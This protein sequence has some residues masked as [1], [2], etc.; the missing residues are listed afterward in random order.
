VRAAV[1]SLIGPAVAVLAMI[2]A[3]NAALRR[4]KPRWAFS[5]G[6]LMTVYLVIAT[7]MGISGSLWNWGGALAASIAYPIWEAGPGNRWAEIMW[8]NLPPGLMVTSRDAL[9]GF[10]LG[11]STPYN[12]EVLRAWATPVFWWTAWVTATLWVMMC[13]SVI[14]R[15]RWS[16]EEQ[17]PF[18]M[19]MVPLHVTDPE[20]RLF[21]SPLWWIGVCVAVGVSVPS[22][23]AIFVPAFPTIS[24]SVDITNFLNNNKPWDAIRTTSLEWGPWAIGLSYLMPLDL[25]FSLLIFNLFW[26]AEYVFARIGGWMTSPWGEAPYGDQQVIGAYLAVVGSVLW[27]D[28]HYLAQVVRKAAGLASRADDNEESFSYRLAVLGGLAGIGF[29]WW[30]YARGGMDIYAAGA[31]LTIPFIMFIAMIRMRA[32]IGPPAHWMYGTMPEFAL[33]QFPGTG[34]IS[35]R[36]LGMIAM[37]RPFQYE[38]DSNPIP[39]QLEGLRMAE[40]G[41]M[42]TRR[43]AWIMIAAVPLIMVSYFW[44]SLHIGYNF[45]LGAKVHPNMTF[46]CRQGTDKLD[47]WLR[48]PGRPNPIGAASIGIGCAVT[49]LLMGLKVRFPLW[50]L[51]PLAFPLAFSWTI[52]SMIPAVFIS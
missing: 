45:G 13:F 33:T 30:F 28:R 49:L 29:L 21:H 44:A 12:L 5:A 32:Y 14:I 35:P 16:R 38:Q 10:F 50:P 36:A 4:R 31:F 18:P 19:T 15:R 42:D 9:Q 46:I 2:T 11:S 40:R 23:I 8:P 37:L 24:T 22:I 51:H 25:A 41:A 17:L 47:A 52:D 43:L 1:G 39:L 7:S 34:A 27:L 3:L 6:E 20:E 26:R 48:E